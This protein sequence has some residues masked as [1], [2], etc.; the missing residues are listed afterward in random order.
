MTEQIAT[1]LTLEW[2]NIQLTERESKIKQLTSEL[3]KIQKECDGFIAL[4]DKLQNENI[5][6]FYDTQKD[7]YNHPHKSGSQEN[8]NE[9]S[10]QQISNYCGGQSPT[11]SAVQQQRT[12]DFINNIDDCDGGQ[13]QFRGSLRNVHLN[14]EIDNCQESNVRRDTV[15][16]AE[17]TP[18]TQP[19]MSGRSA[20]AVEGTS[21]DDSFG[22]VGGKEDNSSPKEWIR[23]EYQNRPIEEVIIEILK[24][25]QPVKPSDVA[26]I[27]YEIEENSPNFERARNS[28]NAALTNGKNQ[29]KWKTLKRGVYVLNDYPESFSTKFGQNGHHKAYQMA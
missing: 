19:P 24:Q 21:T 5:S 2:I 26:L 9:I 18:S 4:L 6:S 14:N 11:G 1:Q 15:D 20:Q 8:S 7:F 25:H 28:A 22:W 23:R 29:K 17:C 10:N 12:G 16:E 27:L 3:E 13:K